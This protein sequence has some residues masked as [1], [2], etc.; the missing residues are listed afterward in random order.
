VDEEDSTE[1]KE[2]VDLVEEEEDHLFFI[3]AIN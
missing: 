3:I 2:E 1:V